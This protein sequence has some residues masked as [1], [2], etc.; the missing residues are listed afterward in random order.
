MTTEHRNEMAAPP[1]EVQ[2]LVP[3][4]GDKRNIVDHA[5]VNAREALARRMAESATQ[6]RLLEDQGHLRFIRPPSVRGYVWQLAAL[7]GWTRRGL[8]YV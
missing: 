6:L 3:Q 8:G 1:A 2:L 4:R 5:L 7:V